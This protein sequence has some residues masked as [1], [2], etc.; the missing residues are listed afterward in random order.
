MKKKHFIDTNKAVTALVVLALIA[1]YDQW[2]NPTAWVYLALHGSYGVMWVLK[3][4]IFPDK[5]WEVRTSLAYGLVIWASLSLYWVAAWL[6][7]SRGV[8]APGWYL[9]ICVSTYAFGVL[10]HFGA[11][12]QK[13]T[14][15]KLKPE[16]LITDGMFRY[17]RNI[18]YLGELLIYLGFGLLPMHWL[19]V[20]I[21]LVWIA[22]IWLPNMR[23]KDRSLMRYPD[24]ADYE[25]KTS[26]FI[27]FLF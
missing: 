22:V 13:F 14:A 15:L 23:R 6:L 8:Q 3:S 1:W 2:E 25:R 10:F 20:A 17:V 24:F 16:H 12:M 9:A 11:D 5:L 18:N 21:L 27:P 7:T 19:P 26:Q 4:R